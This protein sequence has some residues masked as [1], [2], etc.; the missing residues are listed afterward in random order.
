MKYSTALTSWRVCA[1]ISASSSISA[2]PKFRGEV[3]ECPGLLGGDRMRAERPAVGEGDQPLDLDE[4]ARP[5]EPRL[6]QVLAEPF[7][8]GAGSG[9]RAGSGVA[10]EAGS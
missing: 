10:G 4:D 1:S 5:I 3:A 8:G 7:D 9:R 2:A 6:G